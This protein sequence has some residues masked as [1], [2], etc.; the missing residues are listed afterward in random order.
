MEKFTKIE[1]P[2]QN[3]SYLFD[4]TVLSN[5]C[6]VWLWYNKVVRTAS[7][8]RTYRFAVYFIIDPKLA[9]Y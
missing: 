5:V 1:E 9:E 3:K 7:W 4:T 6:P 8:E 2:L